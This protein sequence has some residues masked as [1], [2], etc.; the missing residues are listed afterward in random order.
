MQLFIYS[1][2]ITYFFLVSALGMFNGI[3]FCVFIELTMWA[4]IFFH[5][6]MRQ[7]A[8]ESYTSAHREQTVKTT[9]LHFFECATMHGLT[10][11]SII[12]FK[13]VRVLWVLAIVTMLVISIAT[14]VFTFKS[15]YESPF[16]IRQKPQVASTQVKFL[17][18]NSNSS[19]LINVFC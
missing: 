11:I 9:L 17:I 6:S 18:S 2:E 14:T 12:P 10:Y 1:S 5:A 8:T 7:T 15:Y 4:F 13:A 19:S 16:E 3:S